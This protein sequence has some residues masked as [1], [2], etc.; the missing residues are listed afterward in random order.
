VAIPQSKGKPVGKWTNRGA[1][2]EDYSRKGGAICWALK[3]QGKKVS[4]K[5]ETKKKKARRE[6]QRGTP[7]H[8]WEKTGEGSW[9]LNKHERGETGL[10]K[11]AINKLKKEK[12]AGNLAAR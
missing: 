11:G 7:G 3:D 1:Q 6:S 8:V 12:K 9:G 5:K 2:N 10:G 4:K